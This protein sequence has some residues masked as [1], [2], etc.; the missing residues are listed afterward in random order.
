MVQM[1]GMSLRNFFRKKN[2]ALEEFASI[3]QYKGFDDEFFKRE[4]AGQRW[5]MSVYDVCVS[6]NSSSDEIMDKHLVKS[7]INEVSKI[8]FAY[9]VYV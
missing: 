6:R 9:N 8:D 1:L 7:V 4:Y 3:F 5:F 2:Y